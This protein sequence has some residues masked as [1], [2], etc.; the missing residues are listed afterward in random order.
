M[1]VP[2]LHRRRSRLALQAVL[3]SLALSA[4]ATGTTEVPGVAAPPPCPSW[5]DFPADDHSNAGS[6]YLG[7]TNAANLRSMVANPNDLKQGRPLGP[8]DG[9]RETN[10][11][12]TYEQG[13]VKDFT[14]QNAPR[15]LFVLPGATTGGSQ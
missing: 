3:L 6:P 15:P 9:E 10:A 1:S 7:C 13:Q 14:D 8:A 12:R 2:M 11:V 5:V 4:C